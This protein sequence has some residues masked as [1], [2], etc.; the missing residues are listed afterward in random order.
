MA[1]SALYLLLSSPHSS[2]DL[3]KEALRAWR[4]QQWSVDPNEVGPEGKPLLFAV[5]E[6]FK[7]VVGDSFL[8]N[9]LAQL[10]RS[11]LDPVVDFGGSTAIAFAVE[12]EQWG[13]AMLLEAWGAQLPDFSLLQHRQ[14][15][16]LHGSLGLAASLPDW[17]ADLADPH[18]GFGSIDA[19]PQDNPLGLHP[20]VG[21]HNQ[22]GL[23]QFIRGSNE[24]DRAKTTAENA[25]R[26]YAAAAKV[27]PHSE[28]ALWGWVVLGQFAQMH[29]TALKRSKPDY[30]GGGR[31]MD[32]WRRYEALLVKHRP[33]MILPV[34]EALA[35]ELR[36]ACVPSL[37][38]MLSSPNP[39]ATSL[40]VNGLGFLHDVLQFRANV[41]DRGEG[42]VS[43]MKW[44]DISS[45]VA[46]AVWNLACD[47]AE[48]VPLK[49][50][51]AFRLG[52][53]TFNWLAEYW[54]NLARTLQSSSER[55]LV[56]ERP[57]AWALLSAAISHAVDDKDAVSAHALVGMLQGVPAPTEDL[58]EKARMALSRVDP[59]WFSLVREAALSASLPAVVVPA[60]KP[61]F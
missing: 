54:G 16:R 52:A 41:A 25:F 11:G 5:L 35:D 45:P 46:P 29:R 53:E 10:R 40:G 60:F 55:S 26:V 36:Q 24:A 32:L 22:P 42:Q 7:D 37:G 28:F 4:D 61:R 3:L 58:M 18:L 34:V 23:K 20:L 27:A 6:R 57:G 48:Q 31:A 50:W 2:E 47:F 1:P 15:S 44:G 17:V 59:T 30:N 38:I 21:R 43:S 12:N 56:Q 49:G 19:R 51:E 13:A 8:K 14:L 39:Q 9:L 33:G